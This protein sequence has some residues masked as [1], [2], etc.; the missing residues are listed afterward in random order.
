MKTVRRFVSCA[1]LFA[2]F[3]LFAVPARAQSDAR[4]AY[5]KST[6]Y[7]VLNLIERDY[8]DTV[9]EGT[10]L[11]GSLLEMQKVDPA[12]ST[13]SV[14]DWN[15][16]Q[17]AFD[18]AYGR[19]PE[20][21][22]P[23]GEAAIKGMVK[24]LKD[25]YSLFL[26]AK[27][28]GVYRR[29]M[30]GESFAGIGVELAVKNGRLM[31]TTPLVGSPAEKA[32]ILPGDIIIKVNGESI[33]GKDYYAVLSA[34]DGL[35]GSPISLTVQRKKGHVE[36]TM[37][38]DNIRFEPVSAR[39]IGSTSDTGYISIP[40]FG[41]TTDKEVK[42]ALDI[43]Q[44]R[45]IRDLIIDLRNDPG[46]DFQASLRIAGFFISGKPLVMV[47]KK[48]EPPSPV[49]PQGAAPP[50]NFRS[51]VLIN[52][53]S[54]SAAEV[55]A[56][57]LAENKKAILMGTQSFGKALVQSIYQLPGETALKMTTSRYLTVRGENIHHR[58]LKPDI[59][60]ESVYPFPGI[61]KDPVVQRAVEFLKKGSAR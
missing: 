51:V 28:W 41:G 24:S 14:S 17:R 26:D 9:D 61:A 23:L 52:E 44:K 49:M 42:K 20:K 38:R 59:V 1:L 11:K 53:G 8:V 34:F 36:I 29:A 55:L 40:Y 37:V 21:A 10:V 47:Q 2:L 15:S 56:C 19:H 57:A 32:G 50:F 27:E 58:G 18:G 39:V 45:G 25:P 16:F 7:K 30:N 43:F 4:S 6:L 3:T 33:E 54:A 31:I 60:A 5:I 48:K 12:L 13:A 46:G 22:S 35:R